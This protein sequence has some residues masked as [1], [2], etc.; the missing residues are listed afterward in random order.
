MNDGLPSQDRRGVLLG[1][2][3][4]AA[5]GLA[6]LIGAST[7]VPAQAQ[8]VA[9]QEGTGQLDRAALERLVD[10][11]LDALT[12]HAANR[13]PIAGKVHYTE[14]GVALALDDGLWGTA[15]QAGKYRILVPDVVSQQVGYMGIIR[16]A[17]QPICVTTRL[18]VQDGLITEIETLAAHPSLVGG[19][20]FSGGPAELEKMGTPHPEFLSALAPTEKVSREKLIEVA[21]SYFSAI[22]R[23]TGRYSTPIDPACERRENGLQTTHN[24][25]FAIGKAPADADAAPNL[26]SMSLKEQLDS[27]S[28]A[29][30]TAIRNRRFPVVDEERGNVLAF[31][32]FEHNGQAKTITWADG[33]TRPSPVRMPFTFQITELFK[34]KKGLLRQIE[35]NLIT[36]SYGMKNA[37]WDA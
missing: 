37:V 18:R 25:T 22:E 24:A 28:L 11:Y 13:L 2:G 32:Y 26:M 12:A 29:F 1:V 19:D 10:K 30:V 6:G 8:G 16:E 14:N 27:G 4:V 5:A 21:N 15:Q 31:G 23:S 3:T 36:V 9:G 20:I 17:D 34:I 35:A 33:K 7:S